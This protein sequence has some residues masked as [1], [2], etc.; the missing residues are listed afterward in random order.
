[1]TEKQK[2]YLET[3]AT[4][5]KKDDKDR[6]YINLKK[7]AKV[8]KFGNAWNEVKIQGIDISKTNLWKA[9]EALA[10]Y[11]DGWGKDSIYYDVNKNSFCSKSGNSVT[12][13]IHDEVIKEIKENLK[14]LTD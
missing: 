7:V 4:N 2:K 5:W 14:K 9:R 11:V 6:F 12:E 8:E 13:M 10:S 1:M 3:I